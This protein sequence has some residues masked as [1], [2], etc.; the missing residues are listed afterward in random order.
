[1]VV[2][3]PKYGV[4]GIVYTVLKGEEPVMQLSEGK[5]VATGSDVTISLFDKVKVQVEVTSKDDNN[6]RSK[7]NISLLEPLKIVAPSAVDP[8]RKNKRQKVSKQ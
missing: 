3:I 1:M 7:I 6:H 4:E 8:N 2:L 5:L